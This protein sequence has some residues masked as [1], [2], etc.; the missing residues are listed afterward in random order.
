MDQDNTTARV[1]SEDRPLDASIRIIERFRNLQEELKATQVERDQ[2]REDRDYWK[3][4]TLEIRAKQVRG[5][6]L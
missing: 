1:D 6:V 5:G 2:F 4:K 3:K